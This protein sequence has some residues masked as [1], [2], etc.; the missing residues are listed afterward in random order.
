MKY[1]L[2]PLMV[3]AMAVL[4]LF[5]NIAL[6]AAQ[7][8]KNAKPNNKQHRLQSVTITAQKTEE[9]A[10]EVPMSVSVFG[11]KDIED[12][13]VESV[14][15]LANF[16]PNLMIFANGVSGTN[17]PSM[18][19]IHAFV[20]SLTVSSGLFV[21]GIP[22]LSPIGLEDGL[23][24]IERVEVLRGPQG[25]LYGRNTETGV[26]NIITKKPGNDF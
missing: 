3:L 23:L 1:S 14:L 24:D 17:S 7:G 8:K 11:E 4:L 20:E 5:A 21:D 19:G 10:Q 16:V 13:G 6:S 15:D 2:K 12:M 9:L 22:I 18:R 25:T 26:I